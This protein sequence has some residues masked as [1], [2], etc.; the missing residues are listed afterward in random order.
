MKRLKLLFIIVLFLLSSCIEVEPIEINPPTGNPPSSITSLG[1]FIYTQGDD[2]YRFE[3]KEAG[4]VCWIFYPQMY[5]GG[6]SCL[7][8]DQTL[9]NK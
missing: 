9:L 3:D 6:I 5:S 2:V 4:V 8:K 7:H 1:N